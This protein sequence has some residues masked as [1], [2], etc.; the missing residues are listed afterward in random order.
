MLEECRSERISGELPE[1]FSF[2]AYRT[3]QVPVRRIA[4][5]TGLDMA[6]YIAADPLERLET[7]GLPRELVQMEHILL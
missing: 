3:F 5:L 4:C 2:G 6:P 7:T 1:S